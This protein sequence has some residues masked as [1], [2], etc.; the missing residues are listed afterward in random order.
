MGKPRDSRSDVYSLGVLLYQLTTGRLPFEVNTFAEAARQ[1][2]YQD[3]P[4]PHDVRPDV[5]PVVS[6]AI[7]KAMAKKPENRYQ[8]GAEMAEALRQI[9]A[10]LPERLAA[11]QMEIDIRESRTELELAEQ[12]ALREVSWSIDEDRVTITKDNPTT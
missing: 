8:S 4:S 5:L 12:L 11:A 7:M 10:K 3:P 9:V 1:H 2:P 6:A